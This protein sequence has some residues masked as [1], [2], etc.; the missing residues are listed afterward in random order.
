MT[1][2]EFKGKVDG[3]IAMVMDNQLTKDDAGDA[4]LDCLTAV[5]EDEY[6]QGYYYY[7]QQWTDAFLKMEE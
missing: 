5:A 3:H 6:W 2:E 7:E 1:L 4:I